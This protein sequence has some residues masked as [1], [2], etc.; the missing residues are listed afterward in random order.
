MRYSVMGIFQWNV[1]CKKAR[2][3]IKK[4]EVRF[5]KINFHRLQFETFIFNL[6]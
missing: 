5:K 2:L 6:L 4:M 1:E 3:G